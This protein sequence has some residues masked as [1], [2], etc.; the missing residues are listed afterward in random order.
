M[1]PTTPDQGPGN[2]EAASRA[3]SGTPGRVRQYRPSRGRH[4]ENT[5][6]SA[7]VR[8]GLVPR[9]YLL[10]TRAA[11]AASRAPTRWCRW[12]TAGGAGWSPLMGRCRGCTMPARPGG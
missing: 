2:G 9:S 4:V 10:T 5:V 11:R 12:S 1:P 6:M 3:R 8:A 7:L